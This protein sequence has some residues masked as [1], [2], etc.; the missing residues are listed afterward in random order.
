MCLADKF[1]RC[2]SGEHRVYLDD[3]HSNGKQCECAVWCHVDL[4]GLSYIINHWILEMC[5][6][7]SGYVWSKQMYINFTYCGVPLSPVVYKS[8]M[9]FY[10]GLGE[11]P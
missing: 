1:T 5:Q 9:W 11:F 7:N 6:Y 4:W 2:L 10:V 8:T 3:L